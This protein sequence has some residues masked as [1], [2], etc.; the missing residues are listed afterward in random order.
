M[1]T[2][3]LAC[4]FCLGIMH[5]PAHAEPS[6]LQVTSKAGTVAGAPFGM[7]DVFHNIP[8]AQPPLAQ[9]RW[10]APQPAPPFQGVRDARN[11]GAS[12]LQ[13]DQGW[14]SI[15]AARGSEDCL[16]LNIWRPINAK[17]APVMVWFHGGAFAGGA[18]NTPL[19]DGQALAKA[20]VILVTVNYRLGVLGF[21]AHPELS[22]ENPRGVSGNY[23]LL[24]QIE[25]LRW[26]RSNIA[27]FGGDS[28][29][30]TIF[31][32]SAG[33][34]SVGFLLAAPEAKGLFDRAILQSG[35]P[36]GTMLGNM[37]SIGQAQS[38]NRGFG[39]MAQLRAMPAAE[40]MAKWD[41]FA[42]PAG[43]EGLRL[44]PIVD[45]YVVPRRP[46][47]LF[48]QGALNGKAIITGSNS[49]EFPAAVDDQGRD[50]LARKTFG[51]K[52]TRAL[53]IYA[54]KTDP[55]L[56]GSV[57]D[58]LMT[59]VMFGCGSRQMAAAAP[60]VWLYEFAQPSPGEAAVRHSSDLTYVFGNANKDGGVLS[61]RAFNPREQALSQT[62]ITYWTNFARTGNPNGAGVPKWPRFTKAKQAGMSF[63]DGRAVAGELGSDTCDLMARALSDQSGSP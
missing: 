9:L 1:R 43:A 54:A 50:T 26:V 42:L 18:G 56:R 40:V 19:Y 57:A 21:L 63:V 58:Q 16:Y 30:V 10:R 35:A 22:I 14:N 25:A 15:D 37:A 49:R 29:N 12:C 41:A 44:S 51:E 47:E 28:S 17:R 20:G 62:I 46:A 52:A 6:L 3:A 23:G 39:A 33:A 27:A 4:G 8:Y 38:A 53:E 24:D 7:G 61:T 13:P 5:W 32:Q 60:R 36:Y 55:I 48:S 11:P 34:A 45:G 59:D 2:V 31:G